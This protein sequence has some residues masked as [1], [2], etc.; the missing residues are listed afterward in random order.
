MCG[1]FALGLPHDEIQALH[2]YDGLAVGDWVAR[3]AFVPRFNIAPRSQAPVVCRADAL[4]SAASAN[5]SAAGPSA[6]ATHEEG[7]EAGERRSGHDA[8][9]AALVLH[10]MKWG[11]VPHWSTR[12]DPTLNTINARAEALEEG[13]GMWKGLRARRRCAVPCQGYYEWLKKGRERLPHFTRRADGQLMLLAGLWDVA[14][15]PGHAEPLYTFTIVTTAACAALAWLHDRQPVVLDSADAL[16]T[17]LDVGRHPWDAHVVRL[18]APPRG[19]NL[20]CY[21]VPKEVGKV[22]AE[23]PAF[24][25]PLAARRDGIEAMF[26]RQVAK[27]PKRS[28]SPGLPELVSSPPKKTKSDEDETA[29]EPKTE[30]MNTWEDDEVEILDVDAPSEGPKRKSTS[31]SKEASQGSPSKKKKTARA[32]KSKKPQVKQDKSKI[33]AYFGK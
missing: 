12:E 6:S 23:S 14:V 31:T 18:L 19:E 1:R 15:L 29:E 27:A 11:L 25:E 3:D 21:P 13:T 17:W 10:T 8:E 26:A 9:D 2:G 24:V 22:G 30:K 28:A 33:T 5:P 32:T 20:T 7:R 4:A 16:R